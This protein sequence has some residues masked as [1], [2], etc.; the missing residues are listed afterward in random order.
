MCSAVAFNMLCIRG[1]GEAR[2]EAEL[3]WGENRIR[4][5]LKSAL[6]LWGI[7]RCTEGSTVGWKHMVKYSLKPSN[8][9]GK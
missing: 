6:K 8:L 3:K 2:G 9:D 5:D 1:L 4:A 7:E